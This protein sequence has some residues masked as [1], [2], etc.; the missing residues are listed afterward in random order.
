MGP[1]AVGEFGAVTILRAEHLAKSLRETDLPIEYRRYGPPSS[2][3]DGSKQFDSRAVVGA[4]TASSPTPCPDEPR[5]ALPGR[6]H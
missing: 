3:T 4:V 1:D 2:A 5:T 6:S